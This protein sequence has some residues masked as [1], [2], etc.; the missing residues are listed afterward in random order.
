MVVVYV[1]PLDEMVVLT[2]LPF[3]MYTELLR[4]VKILAYLTQNIAYKRI[5][6]KYLGV[7][8]DNVQ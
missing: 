4:V 5:S 7:I 2:Y 6:L 3:Y 8:N 1:T